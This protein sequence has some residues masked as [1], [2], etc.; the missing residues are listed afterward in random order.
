MKENILIIGGTGFLGYHL[1]LKCKSL[2]WK[3]TSASNNKP[4]KNRKV[5]GVNYISLDISDRKNFFKI[6]KLNPKYV[7]NL[8]GYINHNDQ[9][10]TLKSHFLGVKNLFYFLKNKNIKTFIQIGSSAEYGSINSPQNE[11]D[12]GKPSMVY[13]RSKLKATNFLLSVYKKY[14]FPV[15]ILRF[16]QIYGPKQKIDRFIP[17]L[18][19]SCIKKID[20]ITS[21]GKQKRDFLFVEDAIKAIIR[22]IKCKD[23]RGMIINIGTGKPI[24]L[25]S[26]I[27]IIQ[28]KIGKTKLLL[29]KIK[30]RSD[31]PMTIYPS[32]KKAKKYLNWSKITSFETGI[33]KT[34]K[35]YKKEIKS[36]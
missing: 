23:C 15:T 24:S 10:N 6:K 29:G 2:G 34:I 28:K 8:G 12:L 11:D 19:N 27:K 22:S 21:H 36:I 3:I 20:F 14:N 13:G 25:M 26:I 16:Y 35:Q 32:L 9:V 30:L 1:I 17:L 18:I 7:V 5:K 31:E 4:R 33:N